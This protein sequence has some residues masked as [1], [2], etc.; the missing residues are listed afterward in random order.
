MDFCLCF[1][2]VIMGKVHSNEDV[3]IVGAMHVSTKT[4]HN[5]GSNGN[6]WGQA[7]FDENV[8]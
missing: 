8:R 2:E 5:Q 4:Y 7:H 1:K 6:I 3:T